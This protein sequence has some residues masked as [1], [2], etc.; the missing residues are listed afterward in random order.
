[1]AHTIPISF[2]CQSSSSTQSVDSVT[3]PK[4]VPSRRPAAENNTTTR[5][6][7][8]LYDAHLPALFSNRTLRH[9]NQNRLIASSLA[10][11]IAGFRLLGRFDQR[12]DY[13]TMYWL[14]GWGIILLLEVVIKTMGFLK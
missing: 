12:L 4:T 8:G 6:Y 1:M 5:R 11:Y 3:A 13:L 14:V 7:T 2:P 9:G 10:V